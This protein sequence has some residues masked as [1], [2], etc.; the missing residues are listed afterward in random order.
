MLPGTGGTGSL[1][2]SAVPAN[3]NIHPKVPGE[4]TQGAPTPHSAQ[5]GQGKGPWALP[6]SL[7]VLGISPRP[8]VPA[9]SLKAFL[10][11]GFWGLCQCSSW[12]GGGSG[13]AKG[14]GDAGG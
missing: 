12:K 5:A 14:A 3:T 7:R 8:A 10:G 13:E 6:H 2:S 9:G 4:G 1:P 11:G